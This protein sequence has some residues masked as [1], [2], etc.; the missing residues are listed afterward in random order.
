MEF[1][2]FAEFYP[3]YLSQHQNIVCRRWHFAGSSIGLLCVLLALLTQHW[4]FILV[5]IILGYACAWIGHF[6]HEKN[7]PA[8][9]SHPWYSFLGDWQMFI[10]ILRGKISLKK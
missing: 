6:Y 10:D 5:G 3:F 1:K 2:N 8:T 7:K 9:F 4:R